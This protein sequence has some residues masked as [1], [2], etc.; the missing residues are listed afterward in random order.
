MSRW[1]G[2]EDLVRFFLL[3]GYRHLPRG[4]SRMFEINEFCDG[5]NGLVIGLY[6]TFTNLFNARFLL[7]QVLFGGCEFIVFTTFNIFTN[8]YNIFNAANTVHA[9]SYDLEDEDE[10]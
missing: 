2:M 3:S 10:E 7:G 9:L 5:T 1:R 6:V 8:F 4:S